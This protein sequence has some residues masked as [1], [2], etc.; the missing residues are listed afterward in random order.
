MS[1]SKKMDNVANRVV[2][3]YIGLKCLSPMD[4]HEEHALCYSMVKKWAPD[5]KR[6]RESL[7]DDSCPGKP[8]TVTSKDTLNKIHDMIMADRRIT[9]WYIAT[10]LGIICK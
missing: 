4:I 3:Q 1:T 10:Q 2:I 5:F 6:G 8:S 7:E 9:Q